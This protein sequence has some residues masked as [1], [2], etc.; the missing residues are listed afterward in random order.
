MVSA[1]SR[2]CSKVGVRPTPFRAGPAGGGGRV[3]VAVRGG[4]RHKTMGGISAAGVGWD[5]AVR[6]SRSRGASLVQPWEEG[7]TLGWLGASLRG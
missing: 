4:E 6:S 2:A 3:Y 5:L 1:A 7:G